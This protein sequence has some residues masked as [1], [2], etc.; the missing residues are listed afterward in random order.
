MTLDQ[1][2]GL[3]PSIIPENLY[4]VITQ[5]RREYAFNLN[6]LKTVIKKS[7]KKQL[8]AAEINLA[9]NQRI[10]KLTNYVKLWTIYIKEYFLEKDR[11]RVAIEARKWQIE[12]IFH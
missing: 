1:E 6:R 3:S 4:V 12:T 5:C 2:M 11:R 7:S 10:L 9:F 8:S